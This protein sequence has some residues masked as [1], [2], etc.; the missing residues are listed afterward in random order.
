MRQP[1]M[2]VSPVLATPGICSFSI[3]F[4]HFI[5]SSIQFITNVLLPAR[6]L[7]HLCVVKT[8]MNNKKQ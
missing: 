8:F 1:E 2:A 5:P 7:D 4:M 3:F 6:N